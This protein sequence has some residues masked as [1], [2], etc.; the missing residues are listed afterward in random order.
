MWGHFSFYIFVTATLTPF[1]VILGEA[2]EIGTGEYRDQL[3]AIPVLEPV[4]TR[5]IGYQRTF[6]QDSVLL[7]GKP[8][9]LSHDV[10]PVINLWGLLIFFWPELLTLLLA[11]FILRALIAMLRVWLKC[12][13]PPGEPYCRK[14]KYCLTGVESE[15]CPECGIALN[16]RDRRLASTRRRRLLLPLLSI[17]MC[18]V[19]FT[20]IFFMQ[21]KQSYEEDGVFNDHPQGY[22][23]IH[24]LRVLSFSDW[25]VLDSQWLYEQ[26]HDGSDYITHADT[27]R[28]FEM[29]HDQLVV[30]NF[31]TGE[32]K[33]YLGQRASEG[34]YSSWG[35]QYSKFHQINELIVIDLSK[36]VV[37]FDCDR[38]KILRFEGLEVNGVKTLEVD[39][40]AVVGKAEISLCLSPNGEKLIGIDGANGQVWIWSIESTELLSEL[41]LNLDG[42]HGYIQYEYLDGAMLLCTDLTAD[43]SFVRID[44]KSG[45]MT[46]SGKHEKHEFYWEPWPDPARKVQ[47]IDAID[48]KWVDPRGSSADGR[49]HAAYHSLA[50]AIM[51]YDSTRNAWIA[52]LSNDSIPPWRKKVQ[53]SSAGKVFLSEDPRAPLIVFDLL[54][55]KSIS[56]E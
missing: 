17:S 56:D 35:W 27:L 26:L 45:M 50:D 7:E 30:E 32:E 22:I 29:L 44:L 19:M 52:K 3:N 40:R 37:V 39:N 6:G 41:S 43:G 51:I 9:I 31:E 54:G 12:G 16:R 48:R 4:E 36:E 10:V 8:E 53:F 25:H 55:L 49:F 11:I 18:L 34:H 20:I 2:E 21:D 15:S 14:C 13:P 24:Q 46:K 1:N 23:F 33:I 42:S 5:A 38:R 28:M 47:W